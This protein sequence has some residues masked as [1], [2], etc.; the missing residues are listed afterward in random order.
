MLPMPPPKDPMELA[1]AMYAK[2]DDLDIL[3][4]SGLTSQVA[5]GVKLLGAGV[6]LLGAARWQLCVASSLNCTSHSEP[7]AV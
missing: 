2:P 5:P 7:L 3:Q 6:N 1:P 4:V